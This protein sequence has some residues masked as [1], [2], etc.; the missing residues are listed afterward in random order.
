MSASPSHSCAATPVSRHDRSAAKQM[1]MVVSS[2]SDVPR[3]VTPPP[4]ARDSWWSGTYARRKGGVSTPLQP[5]HPDH[6]RQQ[7]DAHPGSED[8]PMKDRRFDPLHR[9]A[10]VEQKGKQHDRA[11]EDRER[12]EPGREAQDGALPFQMQ[13]PQ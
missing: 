8:E 7:C 5:S 10:I 9:Q 11:T 4:M 12:P 13:Q 2:S 6:E 3:F 1:N